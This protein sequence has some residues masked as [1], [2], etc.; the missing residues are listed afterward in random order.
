VSRNFQNSDEFRREERRFPGESRDAISANAAKATAWAET[1]GV[2]VEIARDGAGQ[3]ADAVKILADSVAEFEAMKLDRA[4]R[5][6]HREGYV[7]GLLFA[8][9]IAEAWLE[10]KVAAEE[11]RAAAEELQR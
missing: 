4:R 11:I 2:A 9:K 5:D 1:M 6:G 7:E 8:A 3:S 10:G